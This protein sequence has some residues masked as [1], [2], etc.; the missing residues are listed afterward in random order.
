MKLTSGRSD[1]SSDHAEMLQV[2]SAV[3]SIGFL[4]VDCDAQAFSK[5]TAAAVDASTA[6]NFYYRRRRKPR[7]VNVFPVSP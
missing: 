2:N 4:K 6:I 7:V 5:R 3:Q 1:E